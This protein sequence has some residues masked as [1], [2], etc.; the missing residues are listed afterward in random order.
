MFLSQLAETLQWENTDTPFSHRAMGDSATRHG[1]DLFALGFTVSQVVHDYGDIC[2]AITELAV[3]QQAPITAGEFQILNRCLDTA[4]ADAVTEHALI[5][6]ASRSTEELERMGQI[7]HEIRNMLNTALRAFDVVKRGTVGQREYRR[8][9]G[10]EPDRAPR[11]RR[12]HALRHSD[13]RESS[14]RSACPYPRCQMTSPSA[15]ISQL[16][17][18]VCNSP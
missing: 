11:S 17:T 9:A 7:T 16:S 2:Q 1:G 8:G 18:A 3:E 13:R 5:T 4:I 14:A 12:Q 6:A 10:P 15:L